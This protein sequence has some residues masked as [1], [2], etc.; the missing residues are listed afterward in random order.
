MKKNI[1]EILKRQETLNEEL[2]IFFKEHGIT[3]FRLTSMGNSIASGYS[4]VRT[5][6]PLLLRNESIKEIMKAHDIAVDH[7]S[8]ARA[9][10]NNDEH[11]HEWLINNTKESEIYQMNRMDYEENSKIKQSSPG[12]NQEKINEYYPKELDI[13]LGLK[14]TILESDE[15]LANIVI[16]NGATGSILD[17]N[18]RGGKLTHRLTYGIKRDI[19]SIEATL[20]Y[21]QNS[22][23]NNNTNTQ[24][25]LCGAPNYLGFVTSV[26]NKKLKRLAKEYA[27]VTYV[28][29]IIP[30]M[31]Y[32]KYDIDKIENIEEAQSI[33]KELTSLR[34]DIHYNELEYLKL[35]NNII[36][37]ISNN[38]DVNQALINADR[39]LYK[40]SSHLEL[41]KIPVDKNSQ[42][43]NDMV[44]SIIGGEYSKIT[45]KDQKNRFITKAKKYLLS[46]LP[47][48]F[49]YVGK[50]NIQASINK[51]SK[52]H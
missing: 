9:Q 33:I 20:K 28:K 16:Y 8:F 7:H 5:I 17:N 49:H 46:R 51:A 13:D 44:A 35:N 21:I 29:P 6:K 40:L 45:N 48:D 50:N 4:M 32:K 1:N 22:N 14:D 15:N 43:V 2:A 19:T 3:N 52:K 42:Y 11:I 47:Y 31:L 39:E 10:N 27:N 38:Y 12:I 41:S 37:S 36:E 23:R 25:Y 34:P 24:V 26:I 18:T 30:K